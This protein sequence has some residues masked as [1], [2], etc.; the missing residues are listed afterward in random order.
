[1]RAPPRRRRHARAA[2]QLDLSNA[3]TQGRFRVGRSDAVHAAQ[4]Y[5]R[6]GGYTGSATSDGARSIRVH[7]TVTRPALFLP[8]IG[9]STLTTDAVA[10]ADLTHGVEGPER[11]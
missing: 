3:Y 1:M 4:S 8:L 2:G 9:I 7:V 5:L 10:T 6:T 11:P